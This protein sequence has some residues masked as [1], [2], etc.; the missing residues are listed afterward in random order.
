MRR[1]RLIR[2]WPLV[3]Y[4]GLLIGLFVRV[5]PPVHGRDGGPLIASADDARL[6]RRQ[7][8][9]FYALLLA[10]PLEWLV[11]GRPVGWG[12]L[13]GGTLLLAGVIG[14]RLAG[15]VL[16]PQLSP[17]VEPREPARLVDAGVYGRLRHPMYLAE[18]AM[19]AGA[20]WLLAAPFSA[21][22]AAVFA[23]VV[24]ARIV[25]EERALRRR[26]PEYAAYAARTYRLIPYVY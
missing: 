4:V 8:R 9:V 21:V 2:L 24:V 1:I 5:G 6:V 14:Y 7:H 13:A 11:R 15:G 12:Q 23:W 10:A 20:P 18:L 3:V 16:G 25:I 19:A 17:L 22:L 26:L